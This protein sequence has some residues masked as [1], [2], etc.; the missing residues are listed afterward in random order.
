MSEIFLTMKNSMDLVG[1]VPEFSSRKEKL[2]VNQSINHE[3]ISYKKTH[4]NKL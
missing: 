1:E 4:N 2:K 3:I